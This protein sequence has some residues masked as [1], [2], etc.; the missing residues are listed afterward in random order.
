MPIGK[1]GG[2]R[3]F[4][5]RHCVVLLGKSSLDSR[6]HGSYLQNVFELNR[7]Y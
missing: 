5:S 7:N 6:K 4:S 2:L 3:L 1:L